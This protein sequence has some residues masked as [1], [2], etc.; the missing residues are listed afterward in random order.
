MT[1]VA[2]LLREHIMAK[3]LRCRVGLYDWRKTYDHERQMSIRNALRVASASA[4]ASQGRWA[5]T[6]E[7]R[8]TGCCFGACVHAGSPAQVALKP[9]SQNLGCSGMNAPLEP[10]SATAPPSMCAGS[11][12]QANPTA[13][14]SPATRLSPLAVGPLQSSPGLDPRHLHRAERITTSLSQLMSTSRGSF[15]VPSV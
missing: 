15:C 7:T 5:D 6:A 11:Y 1:A 13:L 14:L 8:A 2:E 3:P 12:A 4:V 10:G 9:D